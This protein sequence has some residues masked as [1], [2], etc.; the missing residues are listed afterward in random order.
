MHTR[1][2]GAL[3]QAGHIAVLHVLGADCSDRPK[4]FPVPAFTPTGPV[5][6]ATVFL[7]YYRALTRAHALLCAATNGNWL[8]RLRSAAASCDRDVNLYPPDT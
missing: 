6:L 5:T 7:A 3:K 2:F 4:R 1:T 8:E